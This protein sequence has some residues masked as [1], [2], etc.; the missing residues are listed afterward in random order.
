MN[1]EVAALLSRLAPLDRAN[2]FAHTAP[3]KVC[4]AHAR[5]FDAVDFNKCALE[6]DT[7][8]YG[9]AGIPVP[10]FRCDLC[11]FLFTSFCDDWSPQDFSRFIYNDA[12]LRVDGDYSSDRAMRIADRF[13]DRLSQFRS[14]R[15]LD[16]GA[17]RGVFADCM[18]RRGFQVESYDPF[19]LPNRPEGKFDIV[20]CFEVIEHSPDPLRTLQDMRSFLSDDG[21]VFLSQALQPA[22]IGRIRCSWWYAA[23]R[24]GHISMFCDRTF[25]RLAEQ[26]GFVFYRGQSMHGFCPISATTSGSLAAK[27]GSPWLFPVLG[28]P[29]VDPA[30][31]WHAVE[32][33]PAL[34]F[35]W[36][37]RNRL[38]WRAAVPSGFRPHIEV[39]VPF[40]TEIRPGFA[41]ECRVTIGAA[42]VTTTVSE[43][44]VIATAGP[45]EPGEVVVGLK[46]PDPMS[47]AELRNTLDRRRLGLAIRV[48]PSIYSG[49]IV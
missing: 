16:Y 34:R 6:H 40:L 26:A 19:S 2:A 20:T 17:G 10:Y 46:L 45:L 27:V 28:A 7:Y 3:C 38:D 37:A 42:E 23:P 11:G 31:G 22:D 4:G 24:N 49:S 44:A 14:A 12:Y 9:P 5:F 41:A 35:R 25:A 18:N 32:G 30:D 1:P 29:D 21:C 36:S 15:I 33:P 13:A 48:M 43:S 8:L 47:P 39:R